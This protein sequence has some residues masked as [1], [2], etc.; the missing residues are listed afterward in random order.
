MY[1]NW[2]GSPTEDIRGAIHFLWTAFSNSL[3]EIDVI[4]MPRISF[5]SFA[6]LVFGIG[7]RSAAL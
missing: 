5:G 7:M 6:A 2:Y 3:E 4:D 1:A